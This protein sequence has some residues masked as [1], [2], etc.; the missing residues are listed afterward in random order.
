LNALAQ[1]AS[2]ENRVSIEIRRDWCKGCG[3][4]VAFCPKQVLELDEKEKAS[5]VKP[6][7]CTQCGLC[8]LH[9]PD[10]A[11]ELVSDQKITK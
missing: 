3:I 7:E 5:V 6:D 10:M 1:K 2:P 8:E 11:I 9:C 4:C